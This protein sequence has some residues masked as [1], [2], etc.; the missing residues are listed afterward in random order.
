MKYNQINEIRDYLRLKSITNIE[1]RIYNLKAK[2]TPSDSYIILTAES[3]TIWAVENMDI[4]FFDIYWLEWWPDVVGEISDII[5]DIMES[6]WLYFWEF[7][8]FSIICTWRTPTLTTEW[9]FKITMAF[10]IRYLK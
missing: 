6:N 9:K 5:L 4:M 8:T 3:I 7:R 2:N 10:Q 1:D